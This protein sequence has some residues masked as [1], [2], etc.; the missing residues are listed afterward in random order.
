M[1]TF[2]ENCLFHFTAESDEASVSILRLYR[3]VHDRRTRIALCRSLRAEHFLGIE[4]AKP[5]RIE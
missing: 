2:T 3:S 4:L 1:R 5:T